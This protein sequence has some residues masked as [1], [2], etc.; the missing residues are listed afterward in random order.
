[1]ERIVRHSAEKSAKVSVCEGHQPSQ[2]IQPSQLGGRISRG[3]QKVRRLKR[4]KVC[5]ANLRKNK[6]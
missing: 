4:A 3:L 6:L 5:F 1:M 2:N